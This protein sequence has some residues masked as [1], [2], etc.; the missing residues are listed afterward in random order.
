[1]NIHISPSLLIIIGLSYN[2]I[3]AVLISL[4]SFGIKEF[5]EKLR[6]KSTH[7]HIF[8]SIRYVAMIN[9][10][11]V[12]VLINFFWVIGWVV[13]AKSSVSFAI[14]LFPAGFFVWKFIVKILELLRNSIQKLAPRY[15]K[16]EGYLKLIIVFPF[17]IIWAVVFGIISLLHIVAQFGIDLP[18]RILGEKVIGR[19][20]LRLFEHVKK[21]LDKS[22]QTFLK[23]P[24]LLGAAFLILGFIYQIIGTLLIMVR[25]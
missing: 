25:R 1:M 22:P 9:Q 5:V 13:L 7:E 16:G 15:R 10:F 4:E 8:V 6:D 20:L 12:F 23:A 11:S 19:A 17:L 24:I 2:I 21:V 3:G 14:I 18:L